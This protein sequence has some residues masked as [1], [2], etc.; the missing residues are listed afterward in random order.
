MFEQFND[1]KPRAADDSELRHRMA[2]GANWFYWI[3]GL[4][5]INSIISLF[6]GNWN[7]AVGLGI[8][9]IFDAIGKIGAQEGIGSWIEYVFFT[10]DLIVAA[11]FALFGAFANRGQ[12]RAF[13][14]GMILFAFDGLILLFVG[15]V[16]GIIIHA[17]ALYF[18]FT[19][20]TAARKLHRAEKI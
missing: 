12:I 11:V 19:G 15:D 4:S 13:A 18:L 7:F 20:L 3:A 9:Q 2:S 14:A 8:T 5:L 16:L 6:D 10:I 1:A 17:L